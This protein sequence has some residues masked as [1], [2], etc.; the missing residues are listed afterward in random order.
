[1]IKARIRWCTC[2]VEN[3]LTLGKLLSLWFCFLL[4]SI[5]FFISQTSY[6]TY[7]NFKLKARSPHNGN[8]FSIVEVLSQTKT[9]HTPSSKCTLL[10]TFMD[11][12]TLQVTGEAQKYRFY[13]S[14]INIKHNQP[15][16]YFIKIIKI[17]CSASPSPILYKGLKFL[18]VL[19]I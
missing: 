18:F 17:L 9:T 4:H 5:L 1:M 12:V 16:I 14:I 19:K 11:L 7:T 15:M 6:C 2:R 8:H 10:Y 3:I 13:Q